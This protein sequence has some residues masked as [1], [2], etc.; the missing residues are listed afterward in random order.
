MKD[1]PVV[2]CL[3]GSDGAAGWRKRGVGQVGG[4]HVYVKGAIDPPLIVLMMEIKIWML[5]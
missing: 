2:L 3:N 1:N 4:R 5:Q